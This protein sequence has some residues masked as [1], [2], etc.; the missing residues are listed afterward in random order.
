MVLFLMLS[1]LAGAAFKTIGQMADDARSYEYE[2]NELYQ[3]TERLVTKNI[4][5][6]AIIQYLHQQN[7]ELI[8][9]LKKRGSRKSF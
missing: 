9:D 1:L 7:H 4:E 2:V 3:L 5:Q 8:V 6:D